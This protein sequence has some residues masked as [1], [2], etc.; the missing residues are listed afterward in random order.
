MTVE[1]C[2]RHNTPVNVCGE[3]AGDPLAVPLFIGMGVRDLSLNPAR[4]VDTCR[5]IRK[6]DSS[7]VKHLAHSV[8]SSG[9]TVSVK[10]KLQNFK[11]ALDKL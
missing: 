2:R 1:A 3:M 7:N 9:S 11:A 4:I 5:L 6:I 8:L 10:R